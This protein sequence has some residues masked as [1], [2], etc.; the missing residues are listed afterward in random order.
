VHPYIRA[1]FTGNVYRRL[2]SNTESSSYACA[3]GRELVA[4]FG[5]R[6]V[7]GLSLDWISRNLYFTDNAGFIGVIRLRSRHFQD[8]RRLITDVGN[9]RAIVMNPY[10]GY[11]PYTA[12]CGHLESNTHLRRDD[13]NTHFNDTLTWTRIKFFSG[14][15]L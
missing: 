9:P 8:V 2:A 12:C 3:V 6:A 14:L 7:E 13:F 5:L 15:G 10:V 1:V 4:S 11:A